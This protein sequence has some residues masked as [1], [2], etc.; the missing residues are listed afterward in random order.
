VY[1]YHQLDNNNNG[2]KSNKKEIEIV[3]GK[4]DKTKLDRDLF[5]GGAELM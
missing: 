5:G 3:E 4:L 1:Y 2:G